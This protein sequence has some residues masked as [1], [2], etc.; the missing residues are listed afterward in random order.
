MGEILP[1]DRKD[2]STVDLQ[3]RCQPFHLEWIFGFN[4][5]VPLVNVSVSQ[6]AKELVM[7]SGNAIIF[8]KYENQ[9]ESVYTL[10]G[11]KTCINT[12]TSDGSGRFVVSTDSTYCI[13][14]WD[15]KANPD[16]APIAIRT[17]YEPFRESAEINAAGLS[18]DGRYLV[19]ACS[20]S[21]HLLQL[22]QW[23]IGNDTPDDCVELPARLGKTKTINFCS[24]LEKKNHFVVTLE[25]GIIFGCFDSRNQKLLIEVPK[26]HGFQD[27]N[28][29]VFVCDSPRAVSVTAAGMAIV[30]SD[31]QKV[32]AP[33]RKQFLKYLHLKYASINVV[34][35]CD[36]KLI[37][38]DDD[39]EIRFYDTCMRIL[40]WFK[41]ED[42]EPIRTISFDIL[43]R[44]Y[45]LD[46]GHQQAGKDDAEILLL[47]SVPRDVSLEGNPVIIRNF[48]ISTKSGRTFQIDIVQNKIQELYYPSGS[49]ITA[50]DIHPN[51]SQL[52]SCDGNGKI[53]IYDLKGKQATMSLSVPIQRTRRGRI[54]V[55]NYS[56]CGIYLVGGAENGF[57]WMINPVTM[58][59][60]EDS[61]LQFGNEKIR[62]AVFSPDSRFVVF[63]AD[64]GSIGLLERENDCW[65]LI[66][67]N[68][69]HKV[70]EIIFASEIRFLTI[71]DDRHLVE[72][73]IELKDNSRM[74]C[75][76]VG[77][78]FR[79][80]QSAHTISMM[81]LSAEELLVAN[82][83]FKFKIYSLHTF[84]ILHT[85]L[86]PFSDG[87]VRS[88]FL[89]PGAKFF[90]FM[91][92]KNLYIHQLPIDGNPYRF[93]GIFG[94]PKKLKSMRTMKDRYVFC[95]G[96]GDHGV[97]IWRIN[98][99]PVLENL[100]HCGSGLDPYCT[101][102]PGG[103]TG[104]YVKE[105]LSLFF[106]NQISP[107]HTE[108]D[109]E[110]S[111]RDAMDRRDVPN[112][113]RSIGFYMT[114]FEE[115]NLMKEI[116]QQGAYFLTFEEVVKLFLNH[117][118]LAN[119]SCE[120][121][122]TALTY[123]TRGVYDS[124][125][126]TSFSRMLAAVGERI[127]TKSLDFYTK[128]LFPAYCNCPNETA[129]SGSG[130]TAASFVP[131]EEFV[132]KLC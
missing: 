84:D 16:A 5:R 123:L 114:Q 18:H 75:L 15:R 120:D 37:T 105:M 17:I 129:S 119:P 90:T 106:Y 122:R 85:Y 49:I 89:L 3:H 125:D 40:Y 74:D 87:P 127:D 54:T 86:A 51:E 92:D 50:F 53:T 28:D 110:I 131:V 111:I 100:K 11:H 96:D 2:E 128:I 8:Y 58:V 104:C 78:R 35:C 126:V 112:Y 20:G 65:Q 69:T 9:L 109:T 26:K 107:K 23:T 108:E 98:T 6:D 79:L 57:I 113:M 27:Y 94:H 21:R 47:D 1:Y 46:G 66:G 44:K 39:G 14:V 68:D 132:E 43:P 117:R 93:M 102:L 67:R 124:V 33:V 52:C 97:S 95:Y 25:N 19:A 71:G 62:Q 103:K 115:E 63:T 101:L 76:L 82:D 130:D 32:D 72:Y 88:L 48:V 59:I 10:V 91:T 41:Q 77:E 61:P 80:E 13:N 81:L 64:D 60:S 24:D 83:Q 118:T 36:Q 4:P 42:P 38:G 73:I 30:W 12:I 56:P 29:S 22:W 121:I 7:A 99:S 45:V 70:V 116:E 34:R 55:L 31:E